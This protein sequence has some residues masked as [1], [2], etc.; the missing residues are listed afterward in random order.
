MKH[1]LLH[2][3]KRFTQ[4][5]AIKLS[6]VM[7]PLDVREA[8]EESESEA[9]MLF[10]RMIK[11]AGSDLLI[12]PI[13][14]KYYIKNDELQILIIMTEHDITII[15]HIFGY[16]VRV[17]QKTFRNLHG[18]FIKNIEYR[19]NLMEIEYKKN[20]KHSLQTII[21]RLDETKEIQHV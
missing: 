13:S 20:V 2:Q 1:K 8:Y 14:S 21:K 17:S 6:R 3:L 12:S 16:N 19:R 9:A 4:R 10:R 5:L 18:T 15:N 11:D 7:N